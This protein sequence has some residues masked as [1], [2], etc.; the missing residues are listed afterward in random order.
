MKK[1]RIIDLC[2]G[3]GAI[4]KGFE[5]TGYYK[6]VFAA[7]NDKNA[8]LMYSHLFNEYP[9]RDITDMHVKNMIKNIDYDV[10][11]AGF[12]CQ[13][14]SIAGKKK[15]FNDENKGNL[16]FDI[17]DIIKDTKPKAVFLE[18]VKNLTSIENGNTFKYILNF[19][20]NNL[21]YTVIGLKDKNN[22]VFDKSDF[23]VNTVNFGLPQNRERV[24]ILALN[25][26]YFDENARFLTIPKTNNK[27]IFE[28]IEDVLTDSDD[29]S[30]YLSSKYWQYLQNKKEVNK[31]RKSNFGYDIINTGAYPHISNCL[32][33]SNSGLE[34]N[35]IID[36]KKYAGLKV[37]YKRDLI[38]SDGIRFLS[39]I[40]CARLQGLKDYSFIVNGIDKFSFPH[41]LPR[42]RAYQLIGNSV[43][44][45]V[46]ETL[47]EF[48]YR[49]MNEYKLSR[50]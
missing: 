45:T 24:Y 49:I 15:G 23:I 46:I 41:N 38:N 47:A 12:P 34:N 17:C 32:I 10:L 1:Y 39:P 5:K 4:R 43:S 20:A 3:I 27:V 26:D 11:C 8:C 16:F 40:E 36:T 48:L 37:K 33:R 22:M 7:D 25:N 35:L 50:F 21:N 18:N 44:I 9:L 29:I 28:S 19:L 13:P 6:S 14:F 31:A 30:L 2:A 42:Y